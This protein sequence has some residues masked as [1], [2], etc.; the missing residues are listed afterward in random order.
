MSDKNDPKANEIPLP[1]G[2]LRATLEAVRG[3]QPANIC[4][5]LEDALD[6]LLRKLCSA[7]QFDLTSGNCEK[8]CQTVDEPKI[9]PCVHLRWGDGPQDHLETDD[10]E[11]LCITVC[12]PYSNVVLKDFTVQL[13][14]LT[15]AGAAVPNQP[16][17]TPTVMIKPQFN[18]CFGDIPPCDPQSPNQKSCVS[19]E[20]VLIDRGAIAGQYKVLAYYC[21]EACFT[22]FSLRDPA[23]FTLDLVAS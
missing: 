21:F 9:V 4:E 7:K 16:N 11:V 13:I 20:V 5:K 12:N 17:G 23:V 6:E 2:E 1:P 18:I 14:V 3:E 8:R 15:A 10:T 19:R 22:K